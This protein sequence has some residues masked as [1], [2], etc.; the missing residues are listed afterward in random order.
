M[1]M[2]GVLR[3]LLTIVMDLLLLAAGL[4]LAR[5]VIAF[6]GHLSSAAWAKQF[7]DYTKMLVHPFGFGH[8]KTPYGGRFDYNEGAVLGLVLVAEWVVSFVRRFVR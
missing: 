7:M 4:V 6:F 5:I 2:R 3:L 1:T 8:M